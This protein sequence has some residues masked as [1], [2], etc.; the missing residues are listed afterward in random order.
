MLQGEQEWLSVT[1][2]LEDV[3]KIDDLKFFACP[4]STITTRTWQ[5]LDLVNE[6]TDDETTKIIHMPRPGTILDQPHWYREAVKIVR[7]ERNRH[8]SE[9]HEKDMA[10]AKQG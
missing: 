3:L 5:I 7:A 2:E 10:K 1:E 6:T 8:R 4:I 9:Q